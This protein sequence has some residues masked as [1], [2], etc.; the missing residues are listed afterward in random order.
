MAEVTNATRHPLPYGFFSRRHYHIYLLIMIL[1][2]TL[3]VFFS[4]LLYR[5]GSLHHIVLFVLFQIFLI[6]TVSIIAYL[7]QNPMIGIIKRFFMTCNFTKFNRSV[8]TILKYRLH[9]ETIKFVILLWVKYM[10]LFDASEAEFIFNQMLPPKTMFNRYLYRYNLVQHYI[11]I[12][13]YH[14]ASDLIR[15]EF[16]K[17]KK[18]NLDYV[19]SQKD[20]EMF[21]RR[22]IIKNFIHH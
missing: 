11:H 6:S 5:N 22:Y 21:D 13:D 12:E 10:Y 1:T 3:D 2:V 8:S 15:K 17:S 20:L 7:V 19:K 18:T 9:P 14:E 16:E 4:I